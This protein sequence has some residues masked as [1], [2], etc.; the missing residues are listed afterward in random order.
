MTLIAMLAPKGKQ[1]GAAR[2]YFE[3]WCR[4]FGEGYVEIG[5][6]ADN[7]FAAGY[8][9]PGRGLRSWRECMDVLKNLGFIRVVPKGSR[10]YG[11]VLLIAPDIVV[12]RLKAKGKL[13]PAWLMAYEARMIE[14]GARSD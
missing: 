12:S 2:V 9:T 7:A 14:I 6:A 8:T 13:D 10:P 11:C 1:D 3:L 4:D 5:D